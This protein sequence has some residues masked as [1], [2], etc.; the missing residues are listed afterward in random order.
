MKEATGSRRNG[1]FE[2][3]TNSPAHARSIRFPDRRRPGDRRQNA[4]LSGSGFPLPA[5]EALVHRL[6]GGIRAVVEG[7]EPLVDRHEIVAVVALEV[8]VVEVVVV[9]VG[10][11]RDAI[12]DHDPLEPG[13]ALRRREGEMLQLED[14]MERMRRH[15]PVDE[16]GREIEDVLDRMHR[17]SR[18]R[19]D[20]DVLVMERMHG[21]IER[22]PV[23]QAVDQVEVDFAPERDEKEDDQAVDRV[24][25]PADI[26]DVAISEH[27]HAE[28]FEGGP[29]RHRTR[30]VPEDVVE[31]LVAEQERR[32]VARR[33]ANIVLVVGPLRLPGVEPQMEP[34]GDEEDQ[35]HV[36]EKDER[37]PADRE[38]LHRL[39]RRRQIE[40]GDQGDGE[41]GEMPRPQEAW[42]AEHPFEEGDGLRRPYEHR[43]RTE[44][45]RRPVVATLVSDAEL[46]AGC[47]V[48]H[49]SPPLRQPGRSGL[50]PD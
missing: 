33:P 27:P 41:E 16:H 2:A 28:D 24:L 26:R 19:R 48:G 12:L 37:D 45:L 31:Y 17:H 43:R 21:P 40:P 30:H 22:R 47:R 39:H 5:H 49:W 3:A 46:A 7:P 50:P 15:D 14:H 38:G 10:I 8:L 36:A 29:D 9:V 20:V 23:D 4:T 32:V 35:G 13:M 18:P 11:E 34:A 42:I 1:A 44:K 25:F 6:L